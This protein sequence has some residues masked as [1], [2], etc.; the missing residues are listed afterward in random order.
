LS[1]QTQP[2]S[3]E[4]RTLLPIIRMA[5]NMQQTADVSY[6]CHQC[7]HQ[8]KLNRNLTLVCPSCGSEFL[9]EIQSPLNQAS[10]I[11]FHFD[12]QQRNS[13][14]NNDRSTFANA[15]STV[16]QN[17]S[18]QNQLP[19]FFQPFAQLFQQLMQ[20]LQ[21]PG[22]TIQGDIHFHNHN[23][24]GGPHFIHIIPNTAG[25]QQNSFQQI[26]NI[27]QQLLGPGFGATLG[28]HFGDNFE[29]ILNH[30]FQT[31]QWRGPPPA[32]KR[33]VKELDTF[34]IEKED[35]DAKLDCSICKEEYKVGDVAKMLPCNHYF[36]VA[37]I[38]R[39]LERSNM[40]PLCR[41]ELE[42]DDP[43]YERQK[44][45]RQ[46]QQQQAAQG[47]GQGQSVSQQQTQPTNNTNRMREDVD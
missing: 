17:S 12:N 21:T 35:A 31:A 22:I 1:S 18:Q 13:N 14:N 9:E 44:S 33:V 24:N 30:L 15:S 45:R 29:Q 8:V 37:C 43:E 4:K 40:C 2:N 5:S 26:T 6:W 32:S 19:P 28:E 25:G 16:Q 42:T 39:W 47:Q 10:N 38:D 3:F 7:N 36:H 23:Y 20:N 34:Q 41:Y 27:L 11:D 46:Q